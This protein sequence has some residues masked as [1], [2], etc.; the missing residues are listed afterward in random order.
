MTEIKELAFLDALAQAD[1]VKR[2]EITPLELVESAI[3][4][5]EKLN[6]S[7]NA[8]ITP[9]FDQALEAARKP[10]PEGPFTGVPFLIKD[11]GAAYAGAPMSLG[12]SLLK[13]FIPGEDS[14]LVLR[15]KRAGLVFVGK[16][17]TPELGLMPTTEPLAFGP[18]RNPWDTNRTPGGSS[19]GAAAAVASGMVPIAHGNDGGGSIRIPA[20]CCGVFGL[21]PTRARNPMGP[22]FGDMMNGL[23]VEHALTRSVRDSAALL[24]AT[25]GPDTGDPYWAPQPEGPYLDEV[26]KDPGRL[27]I[28]MSTKPFRDLPVH[29]DA[30]R[31]ANEAA[32]LCRELGHEVTEDSPDVDGDALVGIFMVIWSAG[33]ASTL[34]TIESVM[35]RPIK[36]EEIE[37]LTWAIYQAG[38]EQ[39]A[40]SFINAITR[41]QRIARTAARFFNKYDLWL[42]PTISEPPVPIGT[43]DPTPENPTRGMGRSGVFASFTPLANLTGQPGMSVPLFWNDEDLP[44]GTQFIGRF[45]DEATLFRLAAQLEQARPWADKKPKISA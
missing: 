25:A 39:K 12:T 37:P 10:L 30:V 45:G 20:A 26:G 2:G 44:I 35:G 4:R 43:F 31:A 15:Q 11:I 27:R 21:K 16:T 32:D 6:P 19:G 17:N 1:L 42:T 24:D 14:E 7:L 13:G 29:E 5:I 18:T 36:Q 41:M 23:V 38:K 22:Q 33:C 40:S 28:A 9:L 8:V 3:A 34:E